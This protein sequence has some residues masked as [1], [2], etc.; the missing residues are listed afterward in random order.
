MKTNHIFY[1]RHPLDVQCSEFSASNLSVG[2][3]AI[4]LSACDIIR[5]GSSI[6]SDPFRL[7]VSGICH[8]GMIGIQEIHPVKNI[9]IVFSAFPETVLLVVKCQRNSV[10]HHAAVDRISKRVV[11]AAA[12]FIRTSQKDTAPPSHD[13]ALY[14]MRSFRTISL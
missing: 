10:S 7:R 14:P 12:F 8:R 3:I 11:I 4:Q 13:A 2:I 1:L 5:E 6:A 9:S